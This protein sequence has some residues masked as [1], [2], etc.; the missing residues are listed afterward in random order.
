MEIR[1]WSLVYR[2]VNDVARELPRGSRRSG[3]RQARVVRVASSHAAVARICCWK[4]R[5]AW[6]AGVS[7]RCT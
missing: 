2:L 4:P 1:T 5:A 6:W 7:R 3:D